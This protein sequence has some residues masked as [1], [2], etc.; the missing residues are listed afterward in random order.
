MVELIRARSKAA[1]KLREG[2]LNGEI[3]LDGEKQQ[4]GGWE[5]PRGSFSWNSAID[6]PIDFDFPRMIR[7]MGY[8]FL[9]APVAVFP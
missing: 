6:R 8:G 4:S 3:E 7:F 2:V 5:S 1:V 9:F